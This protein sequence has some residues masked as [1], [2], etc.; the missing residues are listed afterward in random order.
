MPFHFCAE[1]VMAIMAAIPFIGFIFRRL[2]LW[3]HTNFNCK[4]SRGKN[5]CDENHNEDK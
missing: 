5:H 2:Q 4:N 3:Y 1:E